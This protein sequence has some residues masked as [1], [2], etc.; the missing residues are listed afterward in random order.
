MQVPSVVPQPAVPLSL[1]PPAP[2][3][4]PVSMTGRDGQIQTAYT[5][6]MQPSSQGQQAGQGTMDT[7]ESLYLSCLYS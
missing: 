2:Q 6:Q 1:Q 5:L 7:G 4:V 3:L